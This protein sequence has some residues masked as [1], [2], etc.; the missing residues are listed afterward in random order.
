MIDGP[1]GLIQLIVDL[2]S[3]MKSCVRTCDGI[4]D[5]FPVVSGVIGKVVYC[6]SPFLFNC[7]MDWILREVVMC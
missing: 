4:S 2:Y 1:V 6:M 5:E 3:G 7:F